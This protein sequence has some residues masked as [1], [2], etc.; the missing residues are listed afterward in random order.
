MF[1]SNFVHNVFPT[2][3]YSHL[4]QIGHALPLLAR[5]TMFETWA[6]LFERA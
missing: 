1:C 6:A 5:K 2:V 3:T 4:G